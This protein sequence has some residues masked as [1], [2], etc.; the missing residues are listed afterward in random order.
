MEL[1]ASFCCFLW[2]SGGTDPSLGA[3]PQPTR[4]R[5]L[6]T[7]GP[8]SWPSHPAGTLPPGCW[9]RECTAS[10]ALGT[11]GS[12]P[13]AAGPERG[14]W[15]RHRTLWRWWAQY[16][17]SQ[18]EMDAALRYY[19]LAEDYFSLV[20]I[21]CFQGNIQKVRV[22]RG[23]RGMGRRRQSPRAP[24]SLSRLLRSPTR[25]ATGQRPTTWPASMRAR[26]R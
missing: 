14:W 4:V 16:L 9:P 19:E 18:A 5:P 22:S 8:Q 17:E 23:L 26:R 21:H 12:F 3:A 1:G 25:A 11:R 15:A 20:R 2:E 7:P 10:M 24:C 13:G 6:Q